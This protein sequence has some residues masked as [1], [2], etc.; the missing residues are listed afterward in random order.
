M[1]DER[2]HDRREQRIIPKTRLKSLH[3]L[4]IMEAFIHL[5]G[6]E[7]RVKEGGREDGRCEEEEEEPRTN[8]SYWRFGAECLENR[9]LVNPSRG[10]GPDLQ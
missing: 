7:D 2:R 10:I 9:F 6:E 4:S 3:K 5:P 8:N 1:R